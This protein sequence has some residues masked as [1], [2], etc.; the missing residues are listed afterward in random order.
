MGEV[1]VELFTHVEGEDEG[2]EGLVGC[3]LL[4]CRAPS[5]RSVASDDLAELGLSNGDSASLPVAFLVELLDGEVVLTRPEDEFERADFVLK[6]LMDGRNIMHYLTVE[7][8][9]TRLNLSDRGSHCRG[10][11]FPF[12]PRFQVQVAC[13]LKQLVDLLLQT[14][15]LAL[16]QRGN[17]N[18]LSLE[19]LIDDRVQVVS[20]D[21][22][23]AVLRKVL[24]ELHYLHAVAVGLH[25]DPELG[26]LRL[27]LVDECEEHVVH[28]ISHVVEIR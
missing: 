11:S 6:E 20:I 12:R 7:T 23:E 27:D 21:L 24:D 14:H 19:D 25:P 17:L 16:N 10:L 3:P 28:L 8:V 15:N 13:M 18:S 26:M 22:A 9:S 2:F 1:E 4:L 5:N